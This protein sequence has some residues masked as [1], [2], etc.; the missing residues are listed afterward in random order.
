MFQAMRLSIVETQ[1]IRGQTTPHA[2]S[3]VPPPFQQLT[4]NEAALSIDPV[5]VNPSYP[6]LQ[7]GWTLLLNT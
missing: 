3:A 6:I 5:N 7:V 1:P 2:C 4:E